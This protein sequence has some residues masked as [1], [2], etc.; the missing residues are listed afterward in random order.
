MNEIIKN[1]I[2]KREEGILIKKCIEYGIPYMIARIAGI[3]WKNEGI[4]KAID[5]LD[6]WH[7]SGCIILHL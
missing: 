2:K 7:C 1:I 5:I 6:Q 4:E 3:K